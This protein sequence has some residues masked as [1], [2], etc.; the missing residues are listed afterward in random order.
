[1]KQSSR[2]VALISI[3]LI[4]ALVSAL[5][6]HLLT[7]HALVV[8]H[9]RTTVYGDRSLQYALGAE[10]YARQ[11][12]YQDWSDP[13]TRKL[14]TLAEVWARPA[15]PFDVE[16]GTLLIEI[17]DMDGRFNLNSVAAQQSTKSLARLKTMLAVVAADPAIADRWRD[18]IDADSEA[19]GFGAEDN[20]YLGLPHPYRSANRPAIDP[21]EMRSLEGVDGTLFHLLEPNVVTLPTDAARLN[22][23]TATALALQSLSSRLTLAQ[24]Q[25]LVESKRQYPDT[26]TLIAEIPELGAAADAMKVTSDFFEVLARAEINGVRIDTRSVLYRDPTDGA[27]ELLARDFGHPFPRGAAS[28][29]AADA[30][31]KAEKAP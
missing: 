31:A 21:S 3:L 9:T 12:L 27:I 11:L 1:M 14:D 10:A 13:E 15:V 8:A 24:A 22:I 17:H 18:W 5:V 25:A 29:A 7:R 28:Q 20:Y 19:T 30:D 2:G 23:N 26:Q 4:V 6:Y 16:G